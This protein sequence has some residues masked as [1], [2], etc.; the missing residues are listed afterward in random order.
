MKKPINRF[1]ATYKPFSHITRGANVP[2]LRPRQ[3][4]DKP[5]T[6]GLISWQMWHYHCDYVK[7]SGVKSSICV[8]CGKGTM[9]D[10]NGE[11]YRFDRRM[12]FE[13]LKALIEK[14]KQTP[15]N[16]QEKS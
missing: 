9:Y 1:N 4:G 16:E 14:I 13:A 8:G 12:T 15:K 6:P 11:G 10:V 5:V 7:R 2:K 3:F